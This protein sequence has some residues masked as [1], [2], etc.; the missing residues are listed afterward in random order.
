MV[1]D[2]GELK[3]SDELDE[4]SVEERGVSMSTSVQTRC[5]SHPDHARELR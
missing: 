5:D 2:L 3:D 4:L 1:N